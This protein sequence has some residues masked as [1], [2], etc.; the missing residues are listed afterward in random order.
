MTQPT[1][2]QPFI[3]LPV[4]II[5]VALLP[6]AFDLERIR[7]DSPSQRFEERSGVLRAIPLAKEIN[8]FID[9]QLA[10]LYD[11]INCRGVSS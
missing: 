6:C 3:S 10:C 11:T 2:C 1:G 7:E 9:A 5:P 4:P 8:H